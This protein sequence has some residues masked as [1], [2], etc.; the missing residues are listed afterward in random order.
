MSYTKAQYIEKFGEEAY[1]KFLE[2]RKEIT[3][4]YYDKH[5]EAINA[6]NR[7]NYYK[8]IEREK[9]R[10]RKYYLERI[11]V[12]K[13]INRQNTI[14]R[15]KENGLYNFYDKMR[16]SAFQEKCTILLGKS[17][18]EWLEYTEKM[19][20][21]EA[22]DCYDTDLLNPE[23]MYERFKNN[24]ECNFEFANYTILKYL[25]FILRIKIVKHEEYSEHEKEMLEYFKTTHFNQKATKSVLSYKNKLYYMPGN[26]STGYKEKE[27]ELQKFK[28]VY[29]V[30][31]RVKGLTKDEE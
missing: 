5:K 20:Q 1:K 23:I 6:Y 13:S 11:D 27:S 26:Y 17:D 10:N 2:H 3:K 30:I 31:L 24:V 16:I 18:E 4:R 21:K 28:E 15:C 7:E 14:K 19:L 9:E 25:A 29:D 12:L 8:N 22:E